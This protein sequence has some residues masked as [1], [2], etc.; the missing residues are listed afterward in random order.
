MRPHLDVSFSDG[1]L[2]HILFGKFLFIFLILEAFLEKFLSLDIVFGEITSVTRVEIAFDAHS[3]D[4]QYSYHKKCTYYFYNLLF[5]LGPLLLLVVDHF[6]LKSYV[7][8]VF[9]LI[10]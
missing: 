6:L 2:L 3:N 4:Y 1:T 8:L 10:C 7:Y 5:S 9:V